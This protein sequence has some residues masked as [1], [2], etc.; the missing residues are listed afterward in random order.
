MSLESQSDCL[1]RI[2]QSCLEQSLFRDHFGPDGGPSVCLR[3]LKVLRDM[4]LPLH[5]SYSDCPVYFNCKNGIGENAWEMITAESVCSKWQ[6]FQRYHDP[7]EDNSEPDSTRLISSYSLKTLVLFEWSETPE[8][9]QWTGSNLSQRL[10]NIVTC[11]LFI[12]KRN[13]GLPSFWYEN[14]DVL[15]SPDEKEAESLPEAINRV[16]VILRFVSSF[17]NDTKYFSFEQCIQNLKD[18]VMLTK[19]KQEVTEFLR[20]SLENIF[21]HNIKKVLRA[22]IGERKKIPEGFRGIDFDIDFIFEETV[23]SGIYI[24]ALLN[25]IAPEEELILSYYSEYKK[26]PSIVV[27]ET[28]CVTEEEA[29]EIVKKSRELYREIARKRMNTLGT[30]LPDYR[31]WSQD[32]KPDEMANLLKLLCENF[33]KDLEIWWN[34][35]LNLKKE[36]K[37]P[38]NEA[39][40]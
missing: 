40:T 34:K 17:E 24:N 27:S 15:P 8:D 29:E 14:Y 7:M 20:N 4:T 1:L 26:E 35:I 16:T 33:E 11:L 38:G 12:L 13:K 23:F 37:T 25:K 6:T 9:E 3:M 18:M 19:Q 21:R 5:E 22:S 28:E 10:V 32:F 36:V 2:S 31:L 39:E 30:D